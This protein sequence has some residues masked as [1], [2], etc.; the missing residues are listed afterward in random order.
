MEYSERIIIVII[1][2][3]IFGPILIEALSEFTQ[4]KKN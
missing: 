4:N 1:F 3:V 2:I